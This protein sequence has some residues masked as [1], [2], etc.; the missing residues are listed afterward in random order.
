MDYVISR[1]EEK[2]DALFICI[3]SAH[4][5]VEHFFSEEERLTENRKATIERLVAQLEIAEDDWVMPEPL[6]S[7]LAE[8]Q[9][10][11]LDVSSIQEAKS[12]I[13]VE[14]A[15][16]V[17][18]EEERVQ[19]EANALMEKARLAEEASA[20]QEPVEDLPVGDPLSPP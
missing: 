4:C 17:R 19:A 18:V 6:V 15:E 5:Q 3:T 9:A 20:K 8:A 16:K 14:K 1:Y 10:L 12:A 11:V 13:L 2:S 7:R